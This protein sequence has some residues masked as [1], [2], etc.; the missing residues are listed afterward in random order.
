MTFALYTSA[1]FIGL[2]FRKSKLCTI[3]ILAVMYILSAYRTFDADYNTYLIGYNNLS[4]VA[5]YRYAGYGS[6]LKI[7][8][9]LGL[10]FE[11][12]NR[13]FFLVVFIL[14]II[15]IKKSTPK[16]DRKQASLFL[17]R[18]FLSLMHKNRIFFTYFQQRSLVGSHCGSLVGMRRSMLKQALM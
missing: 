6:F 5:T 16:Y 4:K 13:I 8:S 11:A 17:M 7:F 9:N 15:I 14:L 1:V 3:Y 12:Y 2:I 10:S 18:T